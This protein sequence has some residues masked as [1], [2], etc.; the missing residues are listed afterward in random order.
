MYTKICIWWYGVV[1][2]YQWRPVFDSLVSD[3]PSYMPLMKPVDTP[4]S[5]DG[6]IW[7]PD[8][9]NGETQWVPSQLWW[10]YFGPGQGRKVTGMWAIN[11]AEFQY[12][13]DINRHFG[14]SSVIAGTL[15]GMWVGKFRDFGICPV[16]SRIP[17][18]TPMF[19]HYRTPTYE[20]C[21]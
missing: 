4:L 16:E 1:A 12:R 11:T 20:Y 3:T 9:L 13:P 19:H 2:L 10:N 8:L 18:M 5:P 7:V 14:G 21:I 17:Y 6:F 15:V